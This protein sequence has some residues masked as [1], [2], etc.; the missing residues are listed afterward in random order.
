[1]KIAIIDP[2]GS[3]AGI[4]HYDISLLSGLKNAGDHCYLYSNFNYEDQLISYKKYFH[5]VGV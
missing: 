3:K 5:N 2:V 4:D 1:M